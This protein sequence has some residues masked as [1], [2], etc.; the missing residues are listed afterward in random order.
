MPPQNRPGAMIPAGSN[1]SFSRRWIVGA[2]I[3]S[4]AEPAGAPG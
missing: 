4:V 1:D 3:G 2:G